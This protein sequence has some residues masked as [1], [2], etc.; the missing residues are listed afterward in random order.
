MSS[1]ESFPSDTA[2]NS[3]CLFTLPFPVYVDTDSAFDIQERRI[4]R[5][6]FRIYPFFR[7]GPANFVPAPA[8][9]PAQIPFLDGN[10]GLIVR[11]EPFPLLA[12]LPAMT[13][14]EKASAILSCGKEFKNKSLRY[15]PMDSL[16]I[17]VLGKSGSPE[18]ASKLVN[19]LLDWIKVETRQWW[20]GREMP[21]GGRHYLRSVV[22]ISGKGL[23]KGYPEG[24]GGFTTMRG[25]EVP[26]DSTIWHR[27]LKYVNQ[28]FEPE[29]YHFLLLDAK[30]HSAVNEPRR[31]VIDAA[32]ACE[33]AKDKTFISIVEDQ[34]GCKFK[35]GKYCSGYDLTK[36]INQDMRKMLDCEFS[37][38]DLEANEGIGLL[39]RCRGDLAHGKKRV[40]Q[41]EEL[42]IMIRSAEKCIGW[43]ESLRAKKW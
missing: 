25:D 15:F 34:W 29:D 24:M 14:E 33:Q 37:E 2:S 27:V 9:D 7:S 16:R 20:I 26:L 11:G 19:G 23:F 40:I 38:A 31:A 39:W 32:V 1:S 6:N 8:I 12:G 13:H 22:P 28:N 18:D 30:Y 43:L 36:H 17:D 21:M 10:K 42:G 35:H 3:A 5:R 4:D 41:K